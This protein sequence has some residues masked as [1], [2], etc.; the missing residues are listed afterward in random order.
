MLDVRDTPV[1]QTDPKVLADYEAALLSFQ[2]FV[3][4]PVTQLNKILQAAPDFVLAHLFRAL[5]FYLSS[6]RRYLTPAQASVTSAQAL[7]GHANEREQLLFDAVQKLV[8][9]RWQDA[10]QA[11]DRVLQDYPR[12]ILALQAGHLLDFF[13][14]DAINLRNRPGRVLPEWR[15]DLPGYSYVLGMYAFGLEECNQYQMAEE[16]GRQALSI[17]AVDAW[18]VHA[19]THVMEMQGRTREGITFLRERETDWAGDNGFAYHNWWHLALLHLEHYEDEQVLQIY[20][21]HIRNDGDITL[22]LLD[23][24]ALLW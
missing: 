13:R 9:G 19:V 22:S 15:P 21:A 6:E 11:F 7:L 17:N 18:S 4:D 2:I 23:A 10:S 5:V 14:G 3:G 1:S 20:D 16:Y 24:T 12:D 8:A